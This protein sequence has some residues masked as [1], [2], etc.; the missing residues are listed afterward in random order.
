MSKKIGIIGLPNVGKSLL[1][2]KLT[3]TNQ[4]RSDN[5]PFCTID[6]NKGK[7]AWKDPKLTQLSQESQSKRTIYSE[8]EIHDIAGLIKNAHEGAGLGNQFLS[9][10][11]DVDLVLH[12]VRG[13]EDN[14]IEHVEGEINP[15]L[16]YT[17]IRTELLQADLTHIEKKMKKSKGKELEALKT[18]YDQLLHLINNPS[19]EITNTL[20]LDLLFL[21]PEI[22]IF[23]SHTPHNFL[24]N[25][26]HIIC[27][28]NEINDETIE[29]LCATIYEKL[30]LICFFTTGKEETRAWI[31]EKGS[32]A[33]HAA[34]KIHTDFGKKFVKAK[35]RSYNDTKIRTENKPYIVQNRDIIEFMISK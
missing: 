28:I 17:T 8:I 1:F 10:I 21:K 3:K 19:G 25:L 15:A 12:V 29:Y 24:Q 35:V 27:N 23:N 26:N 13:F 32:T 31:T 9:H 30:N 20:K 2:N 14:D 11:R 33:V 34:T 22:V 18:I 7:V 5:F 4:A 16:D 6:P